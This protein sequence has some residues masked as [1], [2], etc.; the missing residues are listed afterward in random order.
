MKLKRKNEIIFLVTVTTV[1]LLSVIILISLFQ[2]EPVQPE[3]VGSPSSTAT[4]EFTATRTATVTQTLTVTASPT[5]TATITLTPTQTPL[6]SQTPTPFVFDQGVF[7]QMYVLEQ[8][9]PGVINR[10][11]VADDDSFWLASPYAIGRYLPSVKQFTQINLRDPIIGLTSDGNAWILPKSGAPLSTWDGLVGRIYDETNSW[12]VPQG[13]GLPSPFSPA[14]STNRSGDLWLTTA[15]DIRRLQGDQWRIFLPQE[16]TFD[17]PYRK[18]LSTSFVLSHSKI[19]D[20]SW[21]GSCNWSEEVVAG[22]D[23]LR[24]YQEN[25]WQRTELPVTSGCVYALANDISGHLWVAID[26]QLWR[27]DEGNDTWQQWKP[28]TL[29]PTRFTDFDYGNVRQLVASPDGSLWVTFGL[30]GFSGCDTNLVVYQVDGNKWNLRLSDTLQPP[31]LLFGAN[32]T[33][34]LLKPDQIFVLR[35]DEWDAVAS[36]AWIGADID[37]RGRLWL[38]SGELNGQMILWRAAAIP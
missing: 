38:L 3:P 8:V 25:K 23:G 19:D 9:I 7:E 16:M 32:Q 30:C 29:D 26:K 34:W 12:L 6:P 36:I 22:G 15:Y 33:T 17:L 11:M 5:R 37:T 1:L 13:Y 14:F 35:D 21:V 28:P 10:F 31:A 18:T 2:Q 20:V 4:P 24:V 27:L